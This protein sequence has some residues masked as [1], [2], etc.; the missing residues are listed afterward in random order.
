MTIKLSHHVLLLAGLNTPIEICNAPVVTIRDLALGFIDICNSDREE[1][2][3]IDHPRG[4]KYRQLVVRYRAVPQPPRG[5][6]EYQ[7]TTQVISTYGAEADRGSLDPG[8]SQE[9][10]VRYHVWY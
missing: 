4:L 2:S 7:G 6:V 10:V 8:Q 3:W 9:V 5:K 1:S